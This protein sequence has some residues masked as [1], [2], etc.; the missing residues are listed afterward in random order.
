MIS[1]GFSWLRIK[2]I[3]SD[4]NQQIHRAK[5]THQRIAAT[6]RSALLSIEKGPL[7]RCARKEAKL[8]ITKLNEALEILLR[9]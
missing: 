1:Q 3:N 9:Q 7:P 6:I 5:A 4:L 8:E 2:S